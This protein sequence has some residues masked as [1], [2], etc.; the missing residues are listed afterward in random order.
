MYIHTHMLDTHDQKEV[1]GQEEQ[2]DQKE[3][4][5]QEEQM[6]QKE[7]QGQM[8]QMDQKEIQGQME[9][10]DQKEIQGQMEQMDQKEIQGQMEQMVW[11]DTRET[12]AQKVC[13]LN[14]FACK[15]LYH[16]WVIAELRVSDVQIPQLAIVLHKIHSFVWLTISVNLHVLTTYKPTHS[17]FWR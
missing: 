11:M 8:E 9:Q 1:Q 17:G 5:G 13:T 3:I 2:M 6:D 12:L 4:Q 15:K 10:M 7:I 14:C 16:S